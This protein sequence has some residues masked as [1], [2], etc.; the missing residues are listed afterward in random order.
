MAGSEYIGSGSGKGTFTQSGGTNNLGS[1]G[2]L[3]LG[4]FG[5]TGGTY[6]L[7]GPSTL[8]A[9]IEYVGNSGS[10]GLIQNGGLNTLNF[11]SIGVTGRYQF[12]G[13]TLQLSALSNQGVL[14]A[15]A[16][17]GT[18]NF[19]GNGII[20]ISA[21]NVLNSGSMSLSVGPSFL[22]LVPA[23]FNPATAFGSYSNQGETHYA[24]TP[25]T[26]LSGQSFSGAFSLAD[27]L[28]CQGIISS[29]PGSV[30]NLSGGVNVAGTG[31][32]SIGN[33]TISMKGSPSGITGGAINAATENVGYNGSGSLVQSGGTN[34][35]VNL[36]IG[37]PFSSSSGTYSL[38]GPGILIA[39]NENVGSPGIGLMSQ[40]GGAN[41]ATA[42][43]IGGQG[44]YQFS[45]GTLKIA[46][47]ANQGVF[48]VTNCTGLLS[49]TG[50][51]IVD[52]SQAV[53][54]NTGSMS[55]SVG[56]G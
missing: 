35:A 44:R 14:D 37:T 40:T 12:S 54:V 18:M 49:I 45:G 53:L 13:G 11:L 52:L 2:N 51:Q 1:N 3:Y 29:V 25:L 19:T 8:V 47:L 36:S 32:V 15:A 9:N 42:L 5:S 30:I 21:A 7:S 4:Y 23:N 24:G 34:S 33:G 50:S 48:D 16:G 31:S 20:D 41:S 17:T 39:T 10:A 6:S 38:N 27:P 56:P 22:L 55:L 46:E 26:V 43:V 28:I